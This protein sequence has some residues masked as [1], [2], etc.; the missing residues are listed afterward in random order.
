MVVINRAVT[1]VQQEGV[2]RDMDKIKDLSRKQYN[3]I[4]EL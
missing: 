2:K 1:A 4:A 3:F